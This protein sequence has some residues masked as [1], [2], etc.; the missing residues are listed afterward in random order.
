[1]L[2]GVNPTFA[3]PGATP[4]ERAARA[5]LERN[6]QRP[7]PGPAF[8]QLD[9]NS[10]GQLVPEELTEQAWN[11][12][13]GSD[14]NDD[15]AI[16]LDELQGRRQRDEERVQ[17]PSPEQVFQQ[18]DQ[19]GDNSLTQDE[20][21][22]PIWMRIS[23]SDG[24]QDGRVTLPELLS[25]R[26]ERE[27]DV[28]RPGGSDAFAKLDANEDGQLTE[29]EV[30]EQAWAKISSADANGDGAVTV[31]ELDAQ[32]ADREQDVRRPTPNAVFAYLDVNGDGALT[33]DEVS[34]NAWQKL[35]RTD[36]NNDNNVT[37][38]EL[39]AARTADEN[40]TQRPSPGEAFARLDVNEDG[41]LTADEVNAHAWTRI[42]QADSN[43]DNAV[44]LQE[45]R[46][47]ETNTNATPNAQIRLM[48]SQDWT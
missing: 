34:P 1:M 9:A 27:D 36:A 39:T 7:N 41:Q 22:P 5:N 29:D 6:V 30:T 14:A 12:L 44:T 32:R 8:Q 37:L 2:S 13:A 16:T 40:N 45:L 38:Q 15:C 17:K 46:A 11:R 24:N 26:A 3:D 35:S 19:N 42:S 43:G 23:T 21:S 18:L 25:T 20:V 28:R 4:A 10:D 31:A 47:A 48:H 33:A